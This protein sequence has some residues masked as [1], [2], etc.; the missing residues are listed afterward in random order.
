MNLFGWS[1]RLIFLINIPIGLA[2]IVL[3]SRM[4]RESRSPRRP[5]V[6]LVGVGLASLGLFL[7]IYPIVEGREAGWPAW[8]LVMLAGTLPVFV[9]FV[10]YERR[11]VRLGKSP[12][13]ALHLLG[14]GT[15]RLGLVLSVIFFSG[16][17]VFFVVL[18]VFFQQGF[19]YS[20]LAAGLMF[21][22]FA[23]GFSAASAVSGPVAARI[24][25]RILNLGTLLMMVGLLGTIALARVAAAAPSPSAL[26]ERML[27]V[28]F[29]LY[30]LGQGLAQ[31]ALINTVVGSSGVSGE[32]A[33]SAAGLFLTTA[34]SSIALGVAAI[35]GVFF[36]RLGTSPTTVTY[37][38]AL[39]SAL[40]CN[41]VLQAAT[42]LLVLWLPRAGL[43]PRR[44]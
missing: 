10:L 43:S 34:Q 20:P 24:G 18:T 11:V 14:I 35:G 13:V 27:V 7:L 6:D 39:S 19:G 40:Y 16:V 3:A 37:F 28:L 44:S 31:P 1:W 22:P 15:I 4:V 29:L 42:F 32:D 17:G 9:G 21:L 33:G 5:T 41:L 8:S 30:G 2:A 25:S 36:S 12:L 23:I 26:D 38:D